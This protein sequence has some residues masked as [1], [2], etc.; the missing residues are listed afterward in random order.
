L[1]TFFESPS[2]HDLNPPG[3]STPLAHTTN[4][5]S[6][7][8]SSAGVGFGVTGSFVGLLEGDGVGFLVGVGVDI[9]GEGVGF[10]E[11]GLDGDDVVGSTGGSVG[12]L[13]GDD[14]GFFVGGTDGDFVGLLVGLSDGGEEPSHTPT[15]EIRVPEQVPVGSSMMLLITSV[16]MHEVSTCGTAFT[17]ICCMSS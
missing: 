16:V 6:V 2:S 7:A 1:C 15:G 11:G 17:F 12:C 13:E 4:L 14:V 9:I 10:L 5:K 8:E 3:P